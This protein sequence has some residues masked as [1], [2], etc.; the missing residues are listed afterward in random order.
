VTALLDAAAAPLAAIH[1]CIWAT[2]LGNLWYLRQHATAPRIDRTDLPRLSVCIP[3]RNE[4]DNLKRLL[5]ALLDQTVPA[6]EVVVWDD[7][8]DDGT[9]SLLQ[10]VDDPRLVACRGEGPPPGWMGKVH[11]L[12][13]ATRRAS[14]DRYLF[15][16]ADVE[17]ADPEALRRLVERFEALPSA[18]VASG[19]PRYQGGASLL[20]SLVPSALLTGLPWPLVRPFRASSLA[21]L[22]GQCWMIDADAY[23]THEPHAQVRGEILEDVEIGRYLKTEGMTPVL[24]DV[25]REVAVRMYG[26]FREAWRGFRKN[27]YLIL[28]G[29][30]VAFVGLFAFF[31]SVWVLAPVVSLWFLASIWGL[32]LVTDRWTTLPIW[33]TALAPLSYALGSLLQLDSAVHHWTGRVTWKGRSVSPRSHS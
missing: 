7:G 3:A 33:M 16:D 6:L 12:Y 24:L 25:H 31:A 32:K 18:S 9:W 2:L 30:P 1:L 10:G 4:A 23:H 14:G 8:S 11:A 13:Q 15:L 5:P 21:A 22:N 27:A 19:L 29:T 28:G 17:L 20:V 26:S